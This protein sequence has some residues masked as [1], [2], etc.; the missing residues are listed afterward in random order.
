MQSQAEKP[1]APLTPC[2][3]TLDLRPPLIYDT[4][5]DIYPGK[6]D[7]LLYQTRSGV[8]ELKVMEK[9]NG[10][11]YLLLNGVQHGGHIPGQ[12][13]RLVL[14][15]FKSATAALAFIDPPRDLLLVG[16]GM[17]AL[18]AFFRTALPDTNVDV[19]EI[20]PEVVKTAKDWFGL[21][22]DDR[23]R[24]Y[25]GDG[26]E[27]VRGAKKQYDAIFLD[28]Y[29]DVSVPTHLTT[30]EFIR[31][32]KGAL[33]PGGAAVSNLWGS[34]VNPL[35]D[36]CVRTLQEV[37]PQLYQFRSYTYNYIF[38]CS[39]EEEEV[40]AHELLARAKKI[41]YKTGLGYSLLDMFRKNYKHV[42]SDDY[43][44]AK[45]ITDEDVKKG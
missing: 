2:P 15:Y 10:F 31:E 13:H 17:G 20:D 14:P 39:T 5:M 4:R 45:V 23:L 28:A 12:S 37:F 16:L 11:R 18:P 44:R 42:E 38:V 35:F 34:V 40:P 36:P 3:L 32:V 29:Q 33:K 26:R 8:Q 9:Q 43:E 41:D 30:V 27:F 6:E 1:H 22:E 25:T 19:I 21:Y 24:V 7:R